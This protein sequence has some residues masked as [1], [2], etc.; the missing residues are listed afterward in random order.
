MRPTAASRTVDRRAAGGA[1]HDDRRISM[2]LRQITALAALATLAA[3]VTVGARSASA[4]PPGVSTGITDITTPLPTLAPPHGSPTID[5]G[6]P[7]LHLPPPGAAIVGAI[8]AKYDEVLGL[9]SLG[10]ASDVERPT[11]DGVGRAQEFQ[12]GTIVWHPATGAHVLTGAIRTRWLELWRESWAYPKTDVLTSPDGAGQFAH[13]SQLQIQGAPEVS[14]Y[15]SPG[16][17][18]HEVVGDI[19]GFWAG[20]GWEMGGLGYP[21]EAERNRDG[22]AV[23]RQQAFRYGTV[24][25]TP[26]DG[27]AV[28]AGPIDIDLSPITFSNGVPVGGWAHLTVYPDGHYSYRGH[29]HDSGTPSYNVNNLFT[30]RS[31]S[32]WVFLFDDAGRVHGTFEPG[33]RDY[34][35]EFS[36]VDAA[37][38]AHW[39]DL[40][41]GYSWRGRSGADIWLGDLLA[42]AKEGIG[43]VKDIIVVVGAIA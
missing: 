35:W 28:L 16:S 9:W 37:I 5:P 10:S 3:G 36:G 1:A 39:P 43:Y 13:F 34:N 42:G 17:G 38:A 12:Y 24:V 30:L 22:G 8:R 7:P 6:R 15:W 18:A 20:S 19:R 27:A 25:W 14:I 4:L 23:G 31:A 2:N 32:G 29:F 41:R 26:S 33:S 11:Y 21:V 40:S